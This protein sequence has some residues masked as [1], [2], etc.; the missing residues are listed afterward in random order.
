MSGCSS[1]SPSS[2]ERRINGLD[3][4]F[5]AFTREVLRISKAFYW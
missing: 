4:G 5:E 1:C 3:L 2:S